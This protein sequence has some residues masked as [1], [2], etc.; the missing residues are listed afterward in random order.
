MQKIVIATVHIDIGQLIAVS[1]LTVTASFGVLKDHVILV[2][3]I[4]K[5]FG[6]LF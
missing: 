6:N 1:D 3:L 5:G 4:I 2:D